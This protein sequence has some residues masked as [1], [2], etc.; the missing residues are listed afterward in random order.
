MRKFSI[1]SGLLVLL[2]SCASEPT[3]VNTINEKMNIEVLEDSS[4]Q[5]EPETATE[6]TPFVRGESDFVSVS[7]NCASCH[8]SLTD[9]NDN[10]VSFDVLWKSSMMAN[11]AIDPYWIAT[12]S[13]EILLEPE[14]SNVIQDKC[15]TCHMPLA[16]FDATVYQESTNMFGEG[17]LDPDHLLHELAMEGVSCN[18]CHQIEKENFGEKDSFNGGFQLLE[19][20]REWGNRV[21]YGP[22][23]ITEKQAD[24][25]LQ[26]SGFRPIQSDHM[27]DSALCGTCHNLY[28]PYLDGEGNI[29]GEFPEQMTFMEWQNSQSAKDS[30]CQECHMPIVENE[31]KISMIMGG[32]KEYL[33]KHTFTGANTFML[34]LIKENADELDVKAERQELEDSIRLIEEQMRNDVAELSLE[35]IE[36]I[37]GKLIVDVKVNIAVGHK[38][39][40]GYPS[41]RAWLHFT[42]TDSS[43]KIIFESGAPQANGSI[44]GNENDLDERKYEPH[45][46][47]IDDPSQVQIYETILGNTDNEVT[48][49][50]LRAASYLKDNR[51]L[52]VGFDPATVSEDIAVYGLAS[53]DMD[54]MGGSDQLQYQIDV[55]NSSGPYTIFVELLYQSIGSRWANNLNKFETKETIEFFDFYETVE[56]I[57]VLVDS[58]EESIKN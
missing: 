46:L 40:T 28:T 3:A 26:V 15:V 4:P 33:R 43:G 39:P 54:F 29:V 47:V 53:M 48:T 11:A 58:A 20:D 1:L 14:L 27:T 44:T 17:F 56:N 12:V 34:N 13:S 21:A 10:D 36:I 50:L 42:V 52:P 24:L 30:S 32:T 22:L 16:H 7:D 55:S 23:P 37:E 35:S 9:G 57:P 2:I 38:F 5:P 18:L 45:Y 6:I 25:M 51:L 49:V 8:T 31:V 19:P 41:R